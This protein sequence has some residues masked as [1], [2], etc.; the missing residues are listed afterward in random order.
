MQKNEAR[1]MRAVWTTVQ[2]RCRN[3]IRKALKDPK[4]RARF[5]AGI[6]PP[7]VS[8]IQPRPGDIR[9]ALRSLPAY[10]TP[11]G[12]EIPA[13]HSFLGSFPAEIRNAIYDHVVDYPTCRSLFDAYYHQAD[14]YPTQQHNG[15]VSS[16]DFTNTF[17]TPTIFLLCKQITKE[18]LTFLRLRPF[19]FDRLPP[20]IMGCDTPLHLHQFISKPTL[21]NIRFFVMKIS[22]GD[23]ESFSSASVW[24]N[25][26]EEVLAIWAEKN[27]LV[28]LKIIFKVNNLKVERL[29][30]S[31]MR[32]YEYILYQVSTAPLFPVV[33]H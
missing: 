23:C 32:E 9:R 16:F 12:N 4:Q 2:R 17:H 22:L 6:P 8:I 18:A 29:W 10:C 21:Q 7:T 31:E 20:W 27:S 25:A 26:L 24:H 33:L 19:V 30:D 14:R 13:G 15:N 11:V 28:R 5:L 3:R 1:S